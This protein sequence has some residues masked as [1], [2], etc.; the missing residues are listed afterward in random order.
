M[1]TPGNS[2]PWR[3]PICPLRSCPHLQDSWALAKQ[4]SKTC[5]KRP[6]VRRDHLL[7]ETSVAWAN[8]ISHWDHLLY[9]TTLGCTKG[10][11]QKTGCTVRLPLAKRMTLYVC[12]P[13]ADRTGEN[14][15]TH[16]KRFDRH[17][18][19]RTKSVLWKSV[20]LHRIGQ[21][22]PF[23]GN[24]QPTMVYIHVRLS[25]RKFARTLEQNVIHH[26]WSMIIVWSWAFVRTLHS[27]ISQNYKEACCVCDDLEV[28]CQH[29]DPIYSLVTGV[30]WYMVCVCV[31]VC[32]CWH[33][34]WASMLDWW[35]TCC[36]QLLI[37]E[38]RTFQFPVWLQVPLYLLT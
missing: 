22:C 35:R 30:T 31:C 38:G 7:L 16:R 9:K 2:R 1:L 23:F 12:L 29:P 5:V 20:S 4:F 24:D 28:C 15:R 34:Y 32:V 25:R 36:Q 13:S 27:P 21:N 3:C 14:N 10:W 11:S 19:Q 37:W 33:G 8:L 17:W 26:G 18:V 6:L